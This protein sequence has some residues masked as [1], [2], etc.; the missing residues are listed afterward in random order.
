MKSSWG[1]YEL[2][3]KQFL[4]LA[5]EIGSIFGFD[6]LDAIVLHPKTTLEGF[7]HI[8]VLVGQKEDETVLATAGIS[9]RKTR[10]LPLSEVFLKLKNN[11]Q[12]MRD[13]CN[14][15]IKNVCMN[16][17]EVPV[18]Y[19]CSLLNGYEYLFIDGKCEYHEKTGYHGVFVVP[20]TKT[21][22]DGKEY[23]FYQ[24]IPAYKE[25]LMFLESHSLF[26][27]KELCKAIVERVSDRQYFDVKYDMLSEEELQ[28]LL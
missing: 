12:E 4:S 8:D 5:K 20:R 24:I 22:V 14:M 9:S 28:K 16:T 19:E 6:G 10:G 7:R 18:K 25:E 17:G 1:Y 11:T 15:L 13:M 2:S 27:Y 3:N 26:G 21:L 23:L